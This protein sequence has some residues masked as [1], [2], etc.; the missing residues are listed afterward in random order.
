MKYYHIIICLIFVALFFAC[1]TYAGKYI[2]ENATYEFS[3]DISNKITQGNIA[4]INIFSQNDNLSLQII[5]WLENNLLRYGNIVVV[6]RQQINTVLQEQEFGISGYVDD[7]SAQRI[8][9][10]LG[11]KY[12]LSGELINI[13]GDNI[14]NLQVLE[15]ETAKLVYSNS[16]K[17]EEVE[18]NKKNKPLRF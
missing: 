17:I 15:V 5:R 13:G 10:I 9:Y 2:L 1:Q 12:V 3:Q 8:G 11:A 4:V 16:F 14:L 7:M 18:E 6:S